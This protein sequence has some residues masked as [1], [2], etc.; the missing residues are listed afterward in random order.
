VH[1]YPCDHFDVWPGND[2]FSKT[3]ADQTA[4]LARTFSV[5][6]GALVD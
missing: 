1:H 4:F 3:V 5:V 6:R 2:W